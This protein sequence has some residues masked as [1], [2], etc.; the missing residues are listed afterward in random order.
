MKQLFFVLLLCT[1]VICVHAE[2]KYYSIYQWSGD[3]QYKRDMDGHWRI[4]ET[5]VNLTISD[6]IFIGKD[7]AMMLEDLQFN[8]RITAHSKGKMDVMKV[9]DEASDANSESIFASIIK[10]LKR[11]NQEKNRPCDMKIPAVIHRMVEPSESDIQDMIVNSFLWVGKQAVSRYLRNY[12]NDFILHKSDYDNDISFAIE[13]KTNNTYCVNVLHINRKTGIVSLCY[14]LNSSLAKYINLPPQCT[15][16]FFSLT[17]P[18]TKDDIYVLVA[19]EYAYD[20]ESI[21]NEL[22][23]HQITE[24]HGDR[25]ALN[26]IY[27]Q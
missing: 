13:N 8:N 19:T 27:A 16:N 15:Y 3:V 17:F 23:Y 10:E 12:K 14:V 4:A 25:P 11:K 18:K 22:L 5:G 1:G 7:G 20:S 21:N 9:I 2:L 6:S 24:A 26:I